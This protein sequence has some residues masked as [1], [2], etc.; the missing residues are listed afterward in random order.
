[1]LEPASVTSLVLELL[2]LDVLASLD[3]LAVDDEV[4]AS[5]ST[6]IVPGRHASNASETIEP[7]NLRI[8]RS[9]AARGRRRVPQFTQARDQPEFGLTS[10]FY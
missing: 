2:A 10:P 1:M 4:P 7:A 9:C 6:A 3:V 8:P 5:S